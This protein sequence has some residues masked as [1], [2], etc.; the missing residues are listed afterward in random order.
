MK[1]DSNNSRVDSLTGKEQMQEGKEHSFSFPPLRIW[2]AE[3]G[4]IPS[5]GKSSGHSELFQEIFL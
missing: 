3:G 4:A 2:D 1:D 5:W